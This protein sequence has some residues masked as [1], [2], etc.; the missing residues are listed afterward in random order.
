[1]HWKYLKYLLRH[2]WFVLLAGQKLKVPMWRLLLHD[3]SKFLSCEWLPYARSFYG[4]KALYLWADTYGKYANYTGRGAAQVKR[5][6]DAAWLHHQHHNLHHWQSWVLR[7][8]N[9]GTRALQMPEQYVRE[10]VADWYG[11]GRAIT[12]RWEAGEW[13]DKNQHKM[14]MHNATYARVVELLR[15]P[16]CLK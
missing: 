14:M 7:E 15:K 6:F 10:M 9:G 8:D 4:P 2:K 16:L 5:E 1:M 11:A 3:L 12:G 13:F